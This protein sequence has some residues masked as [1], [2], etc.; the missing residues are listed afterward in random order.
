MKKEAV[1]DHLKSFLGRMLSHADKWLVED[2]EKIFKEASDE[3]D[4]LEELD[5]YIAR[6][7]MKSKT[8]RK[9]FDH[10]TNND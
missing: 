8:L 1:S 9:E 5:L 7:E 3:E 4:F 10:K 6:L 2:I